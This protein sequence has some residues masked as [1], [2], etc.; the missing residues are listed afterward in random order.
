[1][2]ADKLDNA[3]RHYEL[4]PRIEAGLRFLAD[5]DLTKLDPGRYEI[6]GDE[7]YVT[8]EDYST[9]P[10]ET[11][12]WETHRNHVDIQC[13]AKGTELVGCAD[14]RAMTSVEYNA[15][16][17]L[18]FVTGP[19]GEFHELTAGCFMILYPDDAHM[20]CV[21]INGSQPVR[22]VVVKVLLED[23]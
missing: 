1:M 16:K 10:R 18:E 17:D 5:T 21:S 7:C 8:I 20:P 6:L 4:G 22:K 2:I 3:E 12:R 9:Q 14:A 15:A 19:D 11:R 13:L 23:S